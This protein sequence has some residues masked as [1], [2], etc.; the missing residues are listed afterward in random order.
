MW[1]CSYRHKYENTAFTISYL[2]RRPSALEAARNSDGAKPLQ[3]ATVLG[4][5]EL[6]KLL[7]E[8]KWCLMS[9]P[10]KLWILCN[11]EHELWQIRHFCLRLWREDFFACCSSFWPRWHSVHASSCIWTQRIRHRSPEQ[12]WVH[13]FVCKLRDLPASV[14]FSAN[15]TDGELSGSRIFLV[16]SIAIIFFQ[17]YSF[18][19]IV[20]AMQCAQ[21][22]KR[23]LPIFE[24]TCSALYLACWRGHVDV[25]RLL[26]VV[27]FQ[28]LFL[29]NTFCW[30]GL[31]WACQASGADPRVRDKEGRS[32][33]DRAAEWGH[34]R[35]VAWLQT[36]RL[37]WL[38]GMPP[39]GL[40]AEKVPAGC[41]WME[42]RSQQ[43]ATSWAELARPDCVPDCVWTSRKVPAGALSSFKCKRQE[44]WSSWWHKWMS[45][46]ILHRFWS[47]KRHFIDVFAWELGL[48][49]TFTVWMKEKILLSFV[50][51]CRV[52]KWQTLIHAISCSS[53]LSVG[54]IK[55]QRQPSD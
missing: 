32:M 15:I 8:L 11:D 42:G 53:N 51:D 33:Q 41:A 22:S 25:A 34:T 23:R 13:R 7:I 14:W 26:Q 12:I 29:S 31:I 47:G 55:G 28:S 39:A 40:Y 6:V 48:S 37:P 36:L 17:R 30:S 10:E 19:S 16:Q 21:V 24:N 1:C 45:F 49:S 4:N 35:V 9:L 18:V 38:G 44:H 54:P 20:P 5:G 50:A 52:V 27:L 46:T 43:S 2:H 3:V